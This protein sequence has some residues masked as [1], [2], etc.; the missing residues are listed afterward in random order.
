MELTMAKDDL[1]H[2][3]LDEG[4]TGAKGLPGSP[5]PSDPLAAPQDDESLSYTAFAKKYGDE[6][7]ALMYSGTGGTGGIGN[8]PSSVEEALAEGIEPADFRASVRQEFTGLSLDKKVDKL[9][10]TN[11]RFMPVMA[12]IQRQAATVAVTEG[13]MANSIYTQVCLEQGGSKAWTKFRRQYLDPHI[14]PS[15]LK[16][17]RNI[18]SIND[19]ED[20]LVLG[21]DRLDRVYTLIK[22]SDL[23]N[24]P[25]PITLLMQMLDKDVDIN[26]PVANFKVNCDAA[27]LRHRLAKQDIEIPFATL[28]TF[29]GSGLKVENEDMAELNYRKNNGGDVTGYFTSLISNPEDRDQLLTHKKKAT[30]NKKSEASKS[31]F[32]DIN[33][34]VQEWQEMVIGINML[35]SFETPVETHRIDALIVQLQILKD[36]ALAQVKPAEKAA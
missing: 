9:I 26:M 23:A 29:C 10:E 27:I 8:V 13:E 31:S 24:K 15:T 21:V 7:I 18:A 25:N 6:T 32:Q 4:V 30:K 12:S 5:P 2:N 20:W 28:K 19:V 1:D 22:E 3:D 33:V 17:Y 36:K 35:E 34:A 14:H 11:K 16:Q